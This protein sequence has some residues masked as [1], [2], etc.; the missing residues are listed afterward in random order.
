MVLMVLGALAAVFGSAFFPYQQA[1]ERGGGLLLILFGIALSGLLPIPS[2]SSTHHVQR[3]PDRSTWWRSGL[4]GLT[5]G[6][7]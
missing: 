1:L 6:A 3:K 4:I 5:F 7:S 2:L